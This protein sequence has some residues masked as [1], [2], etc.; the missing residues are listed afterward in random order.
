MLSTITLRLAET[1]AEAHEPN[2]PWL[3]HDLGEV[4]WGTLAFLIVVGVLWWKAG[5]FIKKSMTGRT[6]RIADE[7]SSAVDERTAGEGE[8]DRIKSALADSDTEAARIVEEARQTAD[9]LHA[10]LEERAH[11][12][13]AALRVRATADLASAQRQAIA[14][15]TAEVSRLALGAAEQ[16]VA[17]NLDDDSQ[18]S[19]IEQYIA[20]VGA[21]N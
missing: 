9:A 18:Q 1:A 3:P 13:A 11:A 4:L 20:Q 10:E 21:T 16:V 15:L 17:T 5:P 8:R 7:M 19:L 12:D 2:G 14:D 6:E